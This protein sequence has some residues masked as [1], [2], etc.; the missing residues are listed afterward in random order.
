MI[1]FLGMVSV[2]M[3]DEG[4]DERKGKNTRSQKN[5]GNPPKPPRLRAP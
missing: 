3:M 1:L 4:D 2:E 5:P